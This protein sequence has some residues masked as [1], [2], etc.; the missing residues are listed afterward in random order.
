MNP[1][2]TQK[3]VCTLLNDFILKVYIPTTYSLILW[4][5]SYNI[6]VTLS[7]NFVVILSLPFSAVNNSNNCLTNK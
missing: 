1:K 6:Q 7:H 2:Q 3:Q 5:Y 4:S